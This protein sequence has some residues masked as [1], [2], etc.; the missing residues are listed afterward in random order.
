I[1]LGSTMSEG[2]LSDS[3]TADSD[4]CFFSEVE[5]GGL[6][7]WAGEGFCFTEAVWIVSAASI[8]GSAMLDKLFSAVFET[9][10]AAVV[11][12]GG[13]SGA[14]TLDDVGISTA[15]QNPLTP[16]RSV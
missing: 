5:V 6:M 12:G 11:G 13:C 2:M 9:I 16:G 1:R 4:T 14:R 15:G 3:E 7:S 10:G 8:A